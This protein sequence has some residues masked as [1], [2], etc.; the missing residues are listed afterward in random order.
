MFSYFTTTAPSPLS[1]PVR[2]ALPPRKPFKVFS[3]EQWQSPFFSKLPAEVR[4]N[5]YSYAFDTGPRELLS[6]EAP[7]LSLLLSCH[8]AYHE[9]SIVAFACQAFPISIPFDSDI[10]AS[11]R[12]ATSHLSPQHIEAITALSLNLAGTYA[13]SRIHPGPATVLSY[14]ALFFPNLRRFEIHLLRGK[15]A[16][17]QDYHGLRTLHND[18][19]KYAVEKYAPPWFDSIIASVTKGYAYQWQSGARWQ[20]EWPQLKDDKYYDLLESINHLRVPCLDLEMSTN[21]IGNVRGVTPCPCSSDCVRWTS[22]DIVQ[23]TGRRIAIDTVYY[24]PEDRPLPELDAETLLGARLGPNAIFLQPGDPPLPLTE[25]T[26]LSGCFVVTGHGH[27]ADEEYWES[28]QRRNGDWR[29]LY[30]GAFRAMLG[31][32]PR[33][34][35]LGSK[36]LNRGDWARLRENVQEKGIDKKDE[37]QVGEDQDRI[38]M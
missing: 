26:N 14:A 18:L 28:V 23:E 4:N 17:D 8:K 16:L 20:A 32:A 10:P 19:Q 13:S 25:K 11:L 3:N 31:R 24:G 33:Q 1:K 37:T 34:E 12:N 38:R 30:K 9:A 7:P 27:D 36:A 2:A 22:V 35:F 21:A 29:A 15:R 5:I 6:V